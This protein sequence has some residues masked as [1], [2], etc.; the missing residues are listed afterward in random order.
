MFFL[1]LRFNATYSEDYMIDPSDPLFG[2]MAD[3]FYSILLQTYGTD[4]VY[5]AGAAGV[6]PTGRFF[7]VLSFELTAEICAS[8]RLV[9]RNA[10]AFQQRQLFGSY[11]RGGIS[12][13]AGETRDRTRTPKIETS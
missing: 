4:H 5:N 7:F 8:L 6:K 11:Q 10:A 9:Q 12:S 2:T 13:N 1:T 3:T